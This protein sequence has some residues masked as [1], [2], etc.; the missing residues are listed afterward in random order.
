MTLGIAARA[1]NFDPSLG[2]GTSA[3]GVAASQ[4]AVSAQDSANRSHSQWQSVAHRA[5][6]VMLERA[7]RVRKKPDDITCVVVCI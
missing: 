4:A 6:A 7:L 1:D 5:A 2:A 3:D